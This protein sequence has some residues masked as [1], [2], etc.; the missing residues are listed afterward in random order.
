[1]DL[2]RRLIV[3]SRREGLALLGRDRGVARDEH[4]G[5]STQ[6]LD[7]E[8][9]R[10]DVE[11]ENILL[12]A[13]ED[14]ALDR[15][16]DRHDFVR[17]HALVRIL[18]EKL[19]DDLLDLGRPCLSPDQNHFVDIPRLDPRVRERLFHRRDRPL[20]EI[21]H[22]LLELRSGERIVEMLGTAL[23]GGDERQVDVGRLSGRQLHLGLLARFLQALER[24]RILGQVDRLIALELCH[25]PVDDALVEVVAAQVRVTVGRLHFELARSF[26]V[27]QLEHR[28]VVSAAAEIEHGDFFILLLVEAVREC[29]SRRLVDDAEHIE[30]RDLP[31]VLGRLALRVVEVGRHRDDRLLDLVAEVVFGGLLHL[32]QDHRG[33]FGRR[34]ALALDFD[35]REIVRSRDDFVGNALNLFGHFRHLAAHEP[36][37]GEDGILGIGY[38]LS[39]CDLTN[40]PLAVF[41]EADD[42]GRGPSTFRVGDDDGISALHHR[43]DRV[44]GSEVDANYLSCHL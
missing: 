18:A 3:V 15:G 17:V 8:R 16:A 44:G 7:A 2:H 1:M 39:L 20:N 25:E 35:H 6:R 37:D 38:R 30:A 40:E 42:R 10:S 41:G 36:L 29:G 27:V 14:R 24:H 21:V 33:D 13:G 5:D 12:L 28:D 31:G 23:I 22:Q 19:L 9:E 43:D 26:D 34:V 32:L 11:Q 4:R